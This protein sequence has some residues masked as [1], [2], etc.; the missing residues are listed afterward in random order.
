MSACGSDSKNI[1]LPDCPEPD[2]SSDTISESDLCGKAFIDDLG[3][4]TYVI[5]SFFSDMTFEF[6][7]NDDNDSRLASVTS[8]TWAVVNNEVIVYLA[9]ETL[10]FRE[11]AIEQGQYC[12][13]LPEDD[14]SHI[15]HCAVEAIQPSLS[16]LTKEF[17]YEDCPFCSIEFFANNTGA[18]N[19]DENDGSSFSFSWSFQGDGTISIVY[20]RAL[21][22]N[23]FFFTE[24]DSEKISFISLNDYADEAPYMDSNVLFIK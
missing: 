21:G 14:V 23:K 3:D 15:R 17:Y 7:G 16:D 9:D 4:D 22:S 10:T 19:G 20:D 5:F 11:S 18:T 12:F 13:Q 8:G 24:Q 2:N 1:T 6:T